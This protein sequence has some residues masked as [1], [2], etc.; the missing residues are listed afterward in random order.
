MQRL[1]THQGNVW[2][3]AT[4]TPIHSTVLAAATISLTCMRCVPAIRGEGE[5]IVLPGA[6]AI[7]GSGRGVLSDAV[8]MW[9]GLVAAWKAKTFGGVFG[10]GIVEW[11][12]IDNEGALG[13]GALTVR[14]DLAMVSG[15]G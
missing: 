6:D 12:S 10:L 1:S 15:I 9:N 4:R 5:E 11:V 14:M 2:E 3:E 8:A 13:G 7:D